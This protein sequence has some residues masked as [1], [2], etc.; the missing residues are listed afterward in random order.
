MPDI[1]QLSIQ[2]ESSADEAIKKVNALSD[3]LKKLR[4]ETNGRFGNVSEK[5]KGISDE[6]QSEKK[7]N[8]SVQKKR[9][10]ITRATGAGSSET[11]SLDIDTEKTKEQISLLKMLK[12]AL[13]EVSSLSKE[14]VTGPDSSTL[15]YGLDS[16]RVGAINGISAAFKGVKKVATT[17]F[18]AI[19]SGA[20]LAGDGIK[21]AGSYVVNKFTA[22]FKSA[23]G[24]IQ[25]W[26]NAIGRIAFYRV[27]RSAIKA[28]TDGFK[29][30]TQNLYQFSKV[31]NTE[32]ASSMD[33][34]ATSSL[35]LKNSLGA[36]AAPLV[37]VVAPAV[38]MLIDKFVA[39]LNAAGKTMAALSGKGS[40][41]QA[42][43]YPK[44][45]AAAT[46]EAS[47]ALKNFTLGIDELN[48][49]DATS[50][51]RTGV[52]ED[53]GQ[54][55]EEVQ[56]DAP[57]FSSWGEGF[58]YF[59]DN[60]ISG[61]PVV[62]ASLLGLTGKINGFSAN[63]YEM[64]TFPGIQE[65]VGQLG[66]DLAVALNNVVSG[67]DW[68]TLGSALGAGLNTALSFLVSFIYTFDWSN[69]GANL[70]NAFNG[71]VDNMDWVQF[72]QFL[73][74]KFKIALETLTGFLLNLDMED[75]AKAA[76]NIAIG[77]FDSM[78]DTIQNIDWFGLGEQVKTFLVNVDWAGVATSVFTAIGTAFGAATEFL[79]GLIHDAWESV[80]GWWHDNAFE[81][82][83][84]TLQG[85]LDGIVEVISNIG[86]WIKTNIFEP[87]INGFKSVFGIHSPSTVMEEM[88]GFMLEG[89]FN[90]LMN[91]GN[92]IKD[93]GNGIIN[94]VK[95]V[96]GIHSP[97]TEFKELGEYA[98]A[99]LDNGFSKVSNI[100]E[101][102][103]TELEYMRKDVEIFTSGT[104]KNFQTMATKSNTAIQSI[105][106]ALN[107][108]PR[109][110]TT[111]HT[112]VTKNESSGSSGGKTKGYASGGFPTTGQMFIAREAGP[113]LVGN[114]GGKTAV[115][116][117]AQI[118][119]GIEEAAYRGFMRA[120]AES[121]GGQNQQPIVVESKLYLDGKQ[122]TSTVEKTQRER[123]ASIMAGGVMQ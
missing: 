103:N 108:I 58:D 23:I 62:E 81:D 46:N 64:F 24:V 9:E 96:L 7:T 63:V 48:V 45:Y 92:K 28:V 73:W 115:A 72:G 109:N 110:I 40:Y 3:A 55:F 67:I 106:S 94:S 37:E 1:D 50:G 31:A 13:K 54:M 8:S 5:I 51:T 104:E 87:F 98:L 119:A 14:R 47:K 90:G 42:I 21:K 36:I 20:K 32:F 44:E 59:V 4:T 34:I 82:G 18:G 68:L 93:F 79:W 19:V 123:G 99:G 61:I 17:T 65:K 2:I 111:V 91:F 29:E 107:A 53:F 22:P 74:S 116:N 122:V 100:T 101:M 6:T 30:G 95:N 27:I 117:N 26:K 16:I 89:L 33:S 52:S 78:V 12:E 120:M 105:T 97:S 83:K 121:G 11:V 118:E 69:L 71:F 49:I 85:L 57:D 39:L 102:L 60:L 77:F 25:K 76:S 113:E 86:A 43:K 114:I 41:T 66:V 10:A 84:F 75:L 15:S 80:V 38:D 56:I 70:A 112:I 35:Y 88:G